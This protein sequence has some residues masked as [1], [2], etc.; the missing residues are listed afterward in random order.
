V[1]EMTTVEEIISQTHE[2]EGNGRFL[3]AIEHDSLVVDRK[4]QLFFWNSQG[5]YGNA[6]DWLIKVM[7]MSEQEA[8]HAII[9]EDDIFSKSYTTHTQGHVTPMPELV[10]IFY[11]YG[12]GYREY[13]YD[14][15]GYTEET[16]NRFRLGY[17]GE[18][19][20]IPIIVDGDFR[21]FQCLHHN[22]KGRKS[23]YIGLGA[24]PFNFAILK[25]TDWVVLTEGPNDAIMLRQNNIPAISQTGGA[26]TWKNMWLHYF[27]KI[28]QI[29]VTYD[30][31]EAGNEGVKRV[32][33][34]LGIDR[35]VAYN[36]W[37]FDYGFDVSNFFQKGG[38]AEGFMNLIR[39]KAVDL[40]Q[41]P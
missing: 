13:W 30:N 32:I 23:W 8:K 18:W 6:Y 24:L 3:R 36:F 33:K 7:G 20:T 21:N 39:E 2:L 27:M 35:T 26:G 16:V 11:N 12:K 10:E 9:A 15:R 28:K 41:V 29:F 25:L 22:P 38:T 40:W 5:I 1:E 37:D 17:N 31:D 19:Y 14:I 34:N 4:R